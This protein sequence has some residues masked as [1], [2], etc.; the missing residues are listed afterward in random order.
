ML[1]FH[2]YLL[3]LKVYSRVSSIIHLS[4]WLLTLI[5]LMM[6][7][8]QN[9]S[10]VCA[11]S[12]IDISIWTS[13]RTLCIFMWNCLIYK[14][15]IL[16]INGTCYKLLVIVIIELLLLHAL[17]FYRLYSSSLYIYHFLYFRTLSLRHC[18]WQNLIDTLQSS[19]AVTSY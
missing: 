12:I 8:W 19:V 18:C 15:I 4:L 10:T 5:S 3:K 16:V 11:V 7:S 9:L 14:A 2:L 1:I 17:L 13:N 6:N